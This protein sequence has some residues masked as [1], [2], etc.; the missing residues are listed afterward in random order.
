MVLVRVFDPLSQGHIPYV[1]RVGEKMR[2]EAKAYLELKVRGLESEG[3][4]EVSYLL[5]QGNAATKIVDITQA[6]HDNLVAICTHCRFGIGRW[7]LG[8]VTDRVVRYS[9]N[10]VLVIRASH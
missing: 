8:S 4:K 3:L 2:V 1:E 10:P 6:T 7:V 5:L 9:G